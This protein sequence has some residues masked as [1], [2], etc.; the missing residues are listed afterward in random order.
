MGHE[1]ADIPQG[2]GFIEKINVGKAF[3]VRFQDF[4]DMGVYE[5]DI[6][7]GRDGQGPDGEG[8]QDVFQGGG[9][10]QGRLVAFPH[11]LGEQMGLAHQVQDFLFLLDRPVGQVARVDRDHQKKGAERNRSGSK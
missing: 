11:T 4:S 6:T 5:E 8:I 7:L 2:G 9:V 10:F 1:L 3:R